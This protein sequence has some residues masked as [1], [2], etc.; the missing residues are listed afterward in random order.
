M[1]WFPICWRHLPG[2]FYTKNNGVDDPLP[3]LP[4]SIVED[5]LSRLPPKCIFQCQLHSKTLHALTTTSYF[6]T[7]MQQNRSNTAV[8]VVQR[9]PDSDGVYDVLELYFIDEE[10]HNIERKTVDICSSYKSK[11]NR[12]SIAGSYDGFLLF[13]NLHWS[14]ESIYY[15]WNPVTNEKITWGLANMH[16]RY[17][18]GF[19]FCSLRRE[20]VLLLV[21]K[22]GAR[23]KAQILN[24]RTKARENVGNCYYPPRRGSPPVII[25]GTLYWMVDHNLYIYAYGDWPRYTHLI[26]SFEMETEKFIAVGYNGGIGKSWLENAQLHLTEL[27]GELCICDD[28]SPAK[29]MLSTLSH[30]TKCWI[31]RHIVILPK[32]GMMSYFRYCSKYWVNKVTEVIHYKKGELFVRHMTKLYAYNLHSHKYRIVKMGFVDHG[33]QATRHVDSLVSFGDIDKIIFN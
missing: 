8:T 6:A 18:C 11:D 1:N 10:S 33:F 25:N 22:N 27:E 17:V 20:H 21:S 29:L 15:L 28:I 30:K 12:I 13:T 23:Y 26:V 9:Y 19:Y 24:I 16:M 5:I 3:D 31:K 4:D 7:Q 14:G 2:F 32:C